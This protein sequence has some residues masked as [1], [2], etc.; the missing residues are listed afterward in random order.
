MKSKAIHKRGQRGQKFEIGII[1]HNGHEYTAGGSLVDHST[2]LVIGYISKDH[3]TL[4]TW[5]GKTLGTLRP[6]GV[7]SGF[8]D[9]TGRRTKIYHFEGMIDGIRYVGKAGLD[10][11]EVIRMRKAKRQPKRSKR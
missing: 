7:G 1:S 11:G 4:R 5:D 3:R 6:T 9:I 2:G 8:R 10:W